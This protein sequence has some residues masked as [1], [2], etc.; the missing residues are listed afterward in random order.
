LFLIGLFSLAAIGLVKVLQENP[1]MLILSIVAVI[2]IVYL[3]NRFMNT[4][5]GNTGK[6]YQQALRT[7][8]KKEKLSQTELQKLTKLRKTSRSIPFKVIEGRKGKTDKDKDKDN[9]T[10][11]H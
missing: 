1:T 6:G 3:V 2:G 11:F 10:H 8:K 4:P 7:Q 5:R 9:Q